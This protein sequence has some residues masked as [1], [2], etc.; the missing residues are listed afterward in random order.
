MLDKLIKA[1]QMF[2]VLGNTLCIREPGRRPGIYREVTALRGRRVKGKKIRYLPL[3]RDGHVLLANE[4]YGA[5]DVVTV[6]KIPPG[7]R[8]SGMRVPADILDY[9]LETQPWTP[10]VQERPRR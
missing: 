4:P 2:Y 3:V 9:E 5:E 8:F 7:Q 6:R 10:P 1:E